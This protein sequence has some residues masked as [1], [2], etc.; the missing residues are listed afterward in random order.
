MGFVVLAGAIS[1]ILALLLKKKT[2]SVSGKCTFQFLDY[3]QN[4]LFCS[5][6]SKNKL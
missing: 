4:H 1:N 3:S 2:N 5:D 6:S